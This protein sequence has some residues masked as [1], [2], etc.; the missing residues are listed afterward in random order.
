MS[1]MDIDDDTA[2]TPLIWLYPD[3]LPMMPPECVDLGEL[4]DHAKE[5]AEEWV[6]KHGTGFTDFDPTYMQQVCDYIEEVVE[7][8]KATFDDDGNIWVETHDDTGGYVYA[9]AVR[10]VWFI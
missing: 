1:R 9:F 6:E 5:L 3:Q 4:K 2:G 10:P 8:G 7:T